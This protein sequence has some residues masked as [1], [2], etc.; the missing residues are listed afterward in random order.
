MKKNLIL[1]LTIIAVIAPQ[2]AFSKLYRIGTIVQDELVFSKNNVL[3]LSKGDWHVV[4][5]YQ[6]TIYGFTFRCYT[7]VKEENKIYLEGLAICRSNLSGK[8]QGAI[9]NA[10][11]GIVFN[12]PYDGCYKRSEY[13]VTEVYRRGNTHNCLVVRHIDTYKEM[14]DP[15]DPSSRGGNRFNMWVEKNSIEVPK[16]TL[17]SYHSYF[18]RL[19]RGFWYQVGYEIN[20]KLLNSPE[21]KFFTEESSEFHPSNINKYK[22][23]KKIMEEWVSLSSKKHQWLEK[24]FYKAKKNHLLHLDKYILNDNLSLTNDDDISSQL[25]SLND[26]FKSG[27]LTKEEFEKAKKKILN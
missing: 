23:H 14:Y 4:D 20:P 15:D 21:L 2:T 18:S 6:E 16:I 19:S 12:D 1:F 22:E 7:V 26:L 3:K 25:K 8:E 24:E 11:I 17:A 13:Y 10:L 9:N 27:A 5:R